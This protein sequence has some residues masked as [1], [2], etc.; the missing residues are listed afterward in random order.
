[1]PLKHIANDALY[2]FSYLQY[3]NQ[4]LRRGS[5]FLI[6]RQMSITWLKSKSLLLLRPLASL[7][8]SHFLFFLCFFPN[9]FFLFCANQLLTQIDIFTSEKKQGRHKPDS[10][11]NVFDVSSQKI[12]ATACFFVSRGIRVTFLMLWSSVT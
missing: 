4:Y 3:E 8:A 1:M 9:L 11:E 5:H 12:I 2:C 10:Q 6:H 7:S